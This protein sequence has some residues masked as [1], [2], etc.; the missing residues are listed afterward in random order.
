MLNV[1]WRTTAV[2]SASAERTWPIAGCCDGRQL[3]G[4]QELG[5]GSF[6][7]AAYGDNILPGVLTN[8]ASSI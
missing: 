5:M 3:L 1:D 7:E 2:L 4:F 8:T 6:G